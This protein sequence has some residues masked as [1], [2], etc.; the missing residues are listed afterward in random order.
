MLEKIPRFKKSD[1]LTV[2]AMNDLAINPVKFHV[3]I[4]NF[5]IER[6]I[7]IKESKGFLTEYQEERLDEWIYIKEQLS[8][9]LLLEELGV[10]RD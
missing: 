9:E 5:A 7:K 8:A 3:E 10:E 2:K 6:L 1:T 4:C